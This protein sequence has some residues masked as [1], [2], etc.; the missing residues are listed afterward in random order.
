MQ[1]IHTSYIQP[2]IDD[3]AKCLQSSLNSGHRVLWLISGGSN[4][5]ATVEVMGKLDAQTTKNLSLMLADERFGPVGHP[6]SNGAQLL[7]AGFAPGSANLIE[8]LVDGLDLAATRNR[9]EEVA[10]AAFAAADEII[11]QLGIGNDGHIAGILPNSP[12]ALSTE[13]VCAYE[14]PEFTRLT[15]TKSPLEQMA[16]AY[17]FVFGD[18][19]SEALELLHDE[20]PPFAD[21]PAQI[22][23]TIPKAYVYNDQIGENI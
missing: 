11:G 8:V 13:F 7:Q 12:A 23:K 19:K 17:A 2:G 6:N 15:L 22:L 20:S 10:R 3:L 21:Q 14:T 16:V 18:S 1:F 5:T 9:Y 4:I